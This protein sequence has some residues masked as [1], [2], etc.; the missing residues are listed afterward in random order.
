M[1]L[2]GCQNMMRQKVICRSVWIGVGYSRDTLPSAHGQV[3]MINATALNSLIL[4]HALEIFDRIADRDTPIR[5]LSISFG[6]VC[7]EQ[8]EGYDFFT[9]PDAVE[10]EKAREKA[11]LGIMDKY[12]KN[13]VLRG[14]N[15]MPGATQRERNGMIGGH[16]AGY[17]ETGKG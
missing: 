4:P 13:A 8:C 3:R 17:D 14:T 1:V 2:H 12:G 15:F 16:R 9:D 7:D 10:S 6:D 11:V 5:K